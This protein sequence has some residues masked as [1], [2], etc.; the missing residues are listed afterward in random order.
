MHP[1]DKT[2]RGESL[3]LS[4][5]ALPDALSQLLHDLL[6][7]FIFREALLVEPNTPVGWRC[8]A[9]CASAGTCWYWCWHSCCGGD[10]DQPADQR[11]HLNEISAPRDPA[12]PGEVKAYTGKPAMAPVPAAGQRKGTVAAAELDPDARRCGGARLRTAYRR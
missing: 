1:G 7:Q 6:T 9:C 11:R 4:P 8:T 12:E 5:H 2:A 3:H 10:A